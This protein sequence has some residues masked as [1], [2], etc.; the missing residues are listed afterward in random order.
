VVSQKNLPDAE[1][2]SIFAASILL[3]YTLA[4]FINIPERELG[5]Q[6]PGIYLSATVNVRTIIVLLVAILTASGADWLLR[7]H[8]LAEKKRTGE[9]WLL[10]ALTAWVIGFPITE[11][12]FGPVW[13]G[14]LAI[15][16]ILLVMVLI[17]EFI[18]IDP[19]DVRQPLAAAGLTAVSFALYLSLVV[20]LRFFGL[21]LILTLPAVMLAGGLVSLRTLNLRLHGKW[22]FVEAIAIALISVQ[23]AAALHYWP[24]SPIG[25]GL[26]LLGATYACTG[27]IANLSE[28]EPVRRAVVEPLV[29]ILVLW[30]MAYWFR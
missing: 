9:H 1:R 7:E 6:L 3:S 18:T 14:S 28:E 8:P 25:Y 17:A 27:L 23:I 2:L 16:G 4:R 15:G 22:A 30:G 12:P 26:A 29:F 24:L 10:P 19:E 11:L 21:R 13:L 20:L 5:I